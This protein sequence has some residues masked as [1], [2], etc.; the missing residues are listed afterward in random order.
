MRGMYPRRKRFAAL[1]K[2]SVPARVVQRAIID[3]ELLIE[4][5]YSAI[6]QIPMYQGQVPLFPGQL[7]RALAIAANL[8]V[9]CVCSSRNGVRNERRS[10]D[11]KRGKSLLGLK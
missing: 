9:T 2:T 1:R 7:R 3:T 4:R 10:D 6:I 11:A 5:G 8:S